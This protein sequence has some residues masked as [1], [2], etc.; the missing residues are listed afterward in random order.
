MDRPVNNALQDYT[1]FQFSQ[2]MIYSPN[3]ALTAHELNWKLIILFLIGLLLTYFLPSIPSKPNKLRLVSGKKINAG[4]GY[5][6]CWI[7]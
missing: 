3:L 2:Q 4:L 7:F 5:H 6:H 1:F